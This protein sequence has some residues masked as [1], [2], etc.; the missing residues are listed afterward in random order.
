MGL[1]I[2]IH[3]CMCFIRQA[4]QVSGE[5]VDIVSCNEFVPLWV[6]WLDGLMR[7]G[8]GNVIGKFTLNNNIINSKADLI[9]PLY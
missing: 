5:T 8:K 6:S 7:F 1:C 9:A 4:Y 2:I 3:K